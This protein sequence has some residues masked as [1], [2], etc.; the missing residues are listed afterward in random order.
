MSYLAFSEHFPKTAQREIPCLHNYDD[1][2]FPR[3][4]YQFEPLFCVECDCR[5]AFIQ[6][7][8]EGFPNNHAATISHGWGSRSFYI[9]WFGSENQD[10]LD[11][12]MGIGFPAMKRQPK[13]A[14]RLLE[15]YKEMVCSD[16][17]YEKQLRQQ[18][19]KFRK[20]MKRLSRSA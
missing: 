13:F 16:P 20:K 5:R 14:D 8:H 15:I 7:A 2:S 9:R 12:M 17:S 6:V 11:D 4:E 10:I 18:Y 3:G 1:D 19:S